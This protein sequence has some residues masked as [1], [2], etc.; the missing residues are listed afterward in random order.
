MKATDEHASLKDRR[1]KRDEMKEK[2]RLA[3]EK[4]NAMVGSG[5]VNLKARGNKDGMPLV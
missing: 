3:Q 5:S 1:D 2:L 4:K